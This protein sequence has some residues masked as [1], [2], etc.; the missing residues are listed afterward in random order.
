MIQELIQSKVDI[1]P[2]YEVISESGEDHN[3]I[4]TIWIYFKNELIATWTW[5]SKKKW[6]EDA[7]KNAYLEMINKFKDE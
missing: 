1:T 4:F 7:A 2:T 5:T 3:K 6:Q